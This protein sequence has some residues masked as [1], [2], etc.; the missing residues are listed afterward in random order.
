MMVESPNSIPSGIEVAAP[1]ACRVLKT[2]LPAIL[3]IGCL[4]CI[5]KLSDHKAQ[6]DEQ[7]GSN[8]AGSLQSGC[9]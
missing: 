7:D 8:L 6:R 2:N 4:A 5:W 9:T 1:V 3:P